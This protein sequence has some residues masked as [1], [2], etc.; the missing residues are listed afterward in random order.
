MSFALLYNPS[1]DTVVLVLTVCANSLLALVVYRNN[2]KSATNTIFALLTLFTILW[3]G[4][5]Y[6]ARVPEF[7]SFSIVAH[8]LGIAFAAVMSTLFFLFAHTMPSDRIQLSRPIYF[9]ILA[10]TV[11][12]VIFNISP[13]AFTGIEIT[14]GIRSPQAG[15]GLIPFAVLSTL[16]SV[17]TIYCLIRKYRRSSGDVRQQFGLVLLGI[18]IMLALIIATVLV[19]II[20]FDSIRFLYLTPIY[21]LVF[22]G[23]T[24]YAITRY[25][26]FHVKILL[27]RVLTIMI[28]LV[29]FARLFGGE[30]LGGQIID[31]IVLV[32]VAVF[33]YFLVRSVRREVEGR[34]QIEKLN[35]ELMA[36]NGRQ[37]K[38][39][40]FIG[41]EVKGFLTKAEATFSLLVD[42]DLGKLSASARPFV[43]RAIDDVRLGVRS[44]SEILL[45]ANL[46]KGTVEFT[47]E[48]FDLKG[49]VEASVEY[50][51]SNAEE[52][53]LELSLE[54][55]PGEYQM[56]G[57]KSEIGD[58]VLRNLLN[59]AVNYTPQGSIAVSLKREGDSF[60]VVVRDTGIGITDED[61][62]HLFTEGGHGKESIKINVHSTGYGLYIAK[63]AVD[64]HKGSI[65]AE[66]EGKG[67]GSTFTVVLPVGNIK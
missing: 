59:N 17:L 58:H 66:S 33:G 54:V 55:A 65:T 34:E 60:V 31:L 12:M 19:P 53:N 51:R 3:L 7:I 42:G 24:A 13:Y 6:I 20:A 61:K 21:T 48:P 1:L 36:T 25:K 4:M 50:A 10:L 16:F 52:H 5:T 15:F 2:P 47:M 37:E 28:V 39:I 56:K 40:H 44:V 9:L 46:K 32:V 30:T 18:V 27:A 63:Q 57:D 62:R 8:R 11:V 43:K 38:L 23:V 29:L 35:K 41:H 22:L 45:S 26:L 14:N 49:L 67:K 64:A